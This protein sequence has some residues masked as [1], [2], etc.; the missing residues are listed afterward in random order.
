MIIIC[1]SPQLA[2]GTSMHVAS[3]EQTNQV[4]NMHMYR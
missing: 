2:A 1:R 4:E 3:T